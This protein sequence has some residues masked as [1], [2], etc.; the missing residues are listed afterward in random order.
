MRHG[1]PISQLCFNS[2]CDKLV[3][4]GSQTTKIW[5][6]PS[7][8][9]IANVPNPDGSRAL[10]ITFTENDTKIIIGSDDELLRSI[11]VDEVEDRWH[12]M[13]HRLL[14]EK[15]PVDGG[16]ITPPS[17][18]AFNSN[19]SRIAV[20]Y[21][22]Y[23]LSVWDTS[24]PRLIGRCQPT[25][26]LMAVHRMSWNPVSD[27]LVG[28]CKT[29]SVFK[30]NPLDDEYQEV[31]MFAHEIQVSPDGK[32]FLTSDSNGTVKVWSFAFFSAIYQLSSEDLVSG[33]A[34]SPNCM[35]FYDLR[36][37][38]INVWEPNSLIRASETG[39]IASDTASDYQTSTSFSH[40]SE[41]YVVT[42]DAIIAM[43]T[44][45][46]SMLFY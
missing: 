35:R 17:C 37:N 44:A 34:F 12:V 6:I 14:Q 2:R 20:G 25:D 10:T 43:A 32:L 4:Y 45:S 28:L 31:T 40:M 42:N 38:T 26:G 41:A 24:E 9:L 39:D 46:T 15:D 29:G 36:W 22:R 7:G 5:A 18:M 21:S 8:Q 23:P 1:E 11:C 27:H 16:V 13:N 3:S 33:L 19:T 30:W